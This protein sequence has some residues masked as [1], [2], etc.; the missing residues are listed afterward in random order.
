MSGALNMSG[1]SSMNATPTLLI[2]LRSHERIRT[3]YY[4]GIAKT[5]PELT[6]NIVSDVADA[7][8]FLADADIIVTHGPHL[9]DKADQVFSHAKRLKWVQGI[10]TGVD[11]IADRP[12][13]PADVI[14][15]NIHGVHGAPMS[16]AAMSLMLALSRKLPRSLE[17]KMQHKWEN[18]PSR[19]LNEKTVGILGL[20]SIAEAM[21]PR[22]KAFNMTVLGI[23]S[24]VREVP[25]FDCIYDK[26]RLMEVVGELDYFIVLTPYNPGTHHMINAEV[27]A[28]MKPDSYLINLARGGVVDETVLLDALRSKRIAG[29]ALDVFAQEPLKP[30]NP[31][32]GLDN[33]IITCHQAATHDNSARNNLPTIQENIRRFL[34]GDL[35]N[36]KNVIV[37]HRVE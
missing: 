17:N 35:K 3:Q 11:N 27:I 25:G 33:V 34:A 8:P 28:A 6:V 26:A 2:I 12:G 23:T 31:L 4:N 1:V 14:V 36:M 37:R 5:F 9:E 10:G 21:G 16:E 7:D 30:D 29:A 13:L 22:F 20:G 24:G 19:L 18:W 15:T 32:W